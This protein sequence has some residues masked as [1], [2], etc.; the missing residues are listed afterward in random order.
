M[1]ML[2]SG[3]LLH[4]PPWSSAPLPCARL[5]GTLTIQTLSALACACKV[6][7]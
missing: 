7:P 2:L 4:A 1:R 5:P 6:R 3:L